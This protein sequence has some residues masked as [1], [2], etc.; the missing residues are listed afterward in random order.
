MVAP[1]TFPAVGR[2]IYCRTDDVSQRTLGEEHIIPRGLGGN[3]V[4]REASCG[5]CEA[6][7]NKFETECIDRQFL[8]A[9][10]HFGVKTRKSGVVP[11][12]LPIKQMAG[13]VRPRRIPAASHPSLIV[14]FAFGEPSLWTGDEPNPKREGTMVIIMLVPDWGERL[15]LLPGQNMMLEKL[16]GDALGLLLAKIGHSYT[17]AKLGID[18]FRPLL[19]DLIRGLPSGPCNHFIGE[20][21]PVQPPSDELHQIELR[22]ETNHLGRTYHIVRVRLFATNKE[23]LTYDVIVGEPLV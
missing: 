21:I 16:R 3:L 18:G 19:T 15:G 6:I 8:A 1:K 12:M 23:T 11:D 17:V 7:I 9:R 4:L 20:R 13:E 22:T 10:P 2:C 5:A 14:Q